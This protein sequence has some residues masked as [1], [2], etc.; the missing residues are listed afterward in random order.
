[1][2]NKN[3]LFW[4]ST[5]IF[6]I[7][8][9]IM[10]PVYSADVMAANHT[11]SENVTTNPSENENVK[12]NETIIT[13][14]T[15]EPEVTADKTKPSINSGSLLF[16]QLGKFIGEGELISDIVVNVTEENL[17][18]VVATSKETNLNNSKASCKKGK[19][20]VHQ[21]I[22]NAVKIIPSKTS[23]VTLTIIAVDDFNN[24]IK[25]TVSKSL[26]PDKNPP[27]IISFG[28][29]RKFNDVYFA[30]S[31]NNKI[32][33]Q[34]KDIGSG[35]DVD[36][37]K[38]NLGELGSAGTPLCDKK[39]GTTTCIW[40][41]SGKVSAESV[42]IVVDSLK[43][44]SGNKAVPVESEIFID[45]TPPLVEKIELFGVVNNQLQGGN[46]VVVKAVIAEENGLVALVNMN[47]LITDAAKKLPK[48][49]LA[50]SGWQIFTEQDCQKET[51]VW[52][53][54]FV[55]ESLK[56]GAGKEDIEIQVLDTGGNKA[57]WQGDAKN[58]LSGSKGKYKVEYFGVLDEASPDFWEVSKVT[59]GIPFIDLD[60]TPL[61]Y[62]RMPFT[63]EFTA[64]NSAAKMLSAEIIG[65]TP[66]KTLPVL[67]KVTDDKELESPNTEENVV[68]PVEN[69]AEKTPQE[70]SGS[71]TS[72][73]IAR[74]LIFGKVF[75]GGRSSP[76]SMQLVLELEPF[77][78]KE[79]LPVK[80]SGG[81]VVVPY[82]CNFNILSKVG[83]N[84]LVNKE[85]QPV[86]VEVTFSY[87]KL[88][89]VNQN[90]EALIAKEKEAVDTGFW[91]AIGT[92]NT[93][94][95][96]IG[97]ALNVY[98]MYQ[99]AMLLW[100]AY[101]VG[102]DS[103]GTLPDGEMAV[104]AYC[105]G[106]TTFKKKAE[107][108]VMDALEVPI[109]I[110]SCKITPANFVYKTWVETVLNIYNLEVGKGFGDKLTANEKA[111]RAKS[112]KDNLF[113]SLATVCVPG[114]VQGLDRLR[115]IKCRKITCLEN[116]VANNIATVQMCNQL[117]NRQICKY[118]V[119]DLWYAL[120]FTQLWDKIVGV[121][122]DAFNNIFS[123]TR[124]AIMIGCGSF[125]YFS[126]GQNTLNVGCLHAYYVL[127]VLKF[128]DGMASF[129]YEISSVIESGGGVNYCDSVLKE[130]APE[131]P[132]KNG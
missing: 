53:C 57:T 50:E 61:T 106:F 99:T 82:T 123:L 13:N 96:W 28:T 88:G 116:E 104:A 87:S 115:Q 52:V 32:V 22:W 43:D 45:L 70:S 72:P 125:C 66:G 126:K 33:L 80:D 111:T 16:S 108:I 92:L 67:K 30:G 65:C 113:L 7:A 21:C 131:N 23:S 36:S 60:T 64:A 118:V 34:V 97:R 6:L 39:E 58:V 27:E 101:S 1:M 103:F 114:L 109:Q 75:P 24:S 117:E 81:Q 89:S 37:I 25:K 12:N 76:A 3:D 112:V 68:I 120:P 10:L 9:I 48:T 54:D 86:N 40:T 122:S 78:G 128:L 100:D 42:K 98:N 73:T 11:V 110:L 17:K 47:N 56:S 79:T 121:F 19:G 71:I 130:K 74:S 132:K 8:L 107:K 26:T 83:S 29:Q 46:Q 129:Y 14:E 15:K 124:V 41:T 127:D 2:N 38:I 90:L 63:V 93:A 69:V 44:L 84:I 102:I 31:G 5:S 95:T 18:S 85:I 94:L 62:S 91:G 49:N 119:G 20:N 35:V 77:D 4:K 55:T 51:G 105:F 59:A